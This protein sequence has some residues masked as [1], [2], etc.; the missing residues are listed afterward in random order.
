VFCDG[1]MSP[2]MSS[3]ATLFLPC[4]VSDWLITGWIVIPLLQQ[5]CAIHDLIIDIYFYGFELGY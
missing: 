3:A 1:W 2:D 4:F 5:G